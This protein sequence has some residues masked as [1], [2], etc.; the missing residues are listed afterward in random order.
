MSLGDVDAIMP[1]SEYSWVRRCDVK[2]R[3]KVGDQIRTVV[4]AI[5]NNIV[6]LSVKRMEIDPWKY[7]DERFKVGMHVKGIVKEVYSYGAFV[8][9][10]SNI[11]GLLHKTQIA[12]Y[13]RDNV[14][15]VLS[16][17]Q[18]IE[19]SILSIEKENHKMSLS[20]IKTEVVN[21]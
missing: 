20:M 16:Q 18:E 11:H 13:S 6:M 17:G 7:I 8:E 14:K 4:I 21:Q 3:L 15:N 9:L 12:N 19:I 2:S 5:N 10:D 1:I